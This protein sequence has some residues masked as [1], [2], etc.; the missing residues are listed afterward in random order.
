MKTLA[1]WIILMPINILLVGLLLMV[2]AADN[3]CDWMMTE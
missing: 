3:F 2:M 1:A